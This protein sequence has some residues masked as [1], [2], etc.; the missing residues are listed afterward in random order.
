MIPTLRPMV[1]A[2][3]SAVLVVE[4]AAYFSPWA[5][6]HFRDSLRQDH[7]CWVLV[8]GETFLGHGVL[9]AAAHEGELLNLCIAPQAQGQGLGAHLL[10]HLL[11]R[12]RARACD[13]VFLEVRDS[14]GAARRLYRRAG[15]QEIGRRR[16]Y[17]PGPEGAEDAR[18][19]RRELA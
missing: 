13:E 4:R 7:E 19:L 16:G 12:A 14:N 11:D 3:L 1:L 9:S 8:A 17:Y 10:S 2:D 15:F 5:E 6:S 18:V